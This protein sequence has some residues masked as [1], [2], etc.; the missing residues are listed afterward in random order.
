MTSA[1]ICHN[2]TWPQSRLTP[3]LVRRLRPALARSITYARP[4]DS[5]WRATLEASRDLAELGV[6]NLVLFNTEA[7]GGT[8]RD[9]TEAQRQL[10]RFLSIAR[11]EYDSPVHEIEPINEADTRGWDDGEGHPITARLCADIAHAYHDVAAGYP[12]VGVIGP[13]FLGGPSSDLV[14]NTAILLAASGRIKTFA[15]HMYGRSI[16]GQPEPGWIWGT[17]EQGIEELS[18]YIGDMQID[19]TEVGCWTQASGDQDAQRRFVEALCH[20]DHPRVRNVYYFAASD[21]VVPDAEM[22]AGKDFGLIDRDGREKPAFA[23]FDGGLIVQKPQPEH[24]VFV[25]GFRKFA[26]LDP[27]L[28][29]QPLE[30]EFGPWDF[31]QAQR[32]TTGYFLWSKLPRGGSLSFLHNDGRKFRWDEGWPTYEQVRTDSRR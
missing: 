28:F 7:Y 1:G 5:S 4:D 3:G 2:G 24:P 19:L 6:R 18:Q 13:S 22:A 20:F 29:G 27:S 17:V 15:I 31:Q 23:A 26:A 14:R 21:W 25:L 32:T 12:G 10:A 9:I 16:G 8:L 11:F 30:N